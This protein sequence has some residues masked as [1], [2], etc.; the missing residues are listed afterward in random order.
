MKATASRDTALKQLTIE[1]N[2]VL[3][4][5][6]ALTEAE[7]TQPDTIEYGLY[8]DQELSFQ[9]LLA[10]LITYEAYAVETIQAWKRGQKH[11]VIDAMLDPRAARRIH[12][13]GIEDRRGQSL[14]QTLEEWETTQVNLMR[15][16]EAL[17]DADWTSPAPFASKTPIDLGGALEIIL[18]APPRPLYRHL[19]VHIPD[20][21][22]YL[23]KLR[24]A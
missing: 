16:I 14:A 17:S 1:H 18:V 13:A 15:A 8:Y 3:A 12:Y 5:I 19:P 4:L 2:E 22:A 21:Q 11:A 24:R 9:D 10:H 6:D 20:S 23:R 7:M